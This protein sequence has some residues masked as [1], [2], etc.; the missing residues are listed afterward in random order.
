MEMN[1]HDYI[2]ILKMDVEGA[3]F[4]GLGKFMDDY[5]GRELPIGQFLVEVHLVNRAVPAGTQQVID[6]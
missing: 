2:D 6:W 3:E 4:A 1:G 5:E